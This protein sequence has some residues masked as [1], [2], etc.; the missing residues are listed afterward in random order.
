M[1]RVS[2]LIEASQGRYP[3]RICQTIGLRS[4]GIPFHASFL[5]DASGTTGISSNDLNFWS[6]VVCGSGVIVG[7]GGRIV[8]SRID[9]SLTRFWVFGL[10]PLGLGV[11]LIIG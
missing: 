10:I 4:S 6:R 2:A 9:G 8:E 7:V 1:V 11:G 5:R 3:R